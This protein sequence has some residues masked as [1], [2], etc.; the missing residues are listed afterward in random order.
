MVPV[1]TWVPVFPAP[2]VQM[3]AAMMSAVSPVGWVRLYFA[4]DA[5]LSVAVEMTAMLVPGLALANRP[6]GT[7]VTMSPSSTPASVPEIEAV[8]VPSK[9]LSEAA[10]LLIVRGLGATDWAGANGADV[11]A[12]WLMFP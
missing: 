2:P 7:S 1:A 11:L 4:A 12:R 3:L 6:E 8:V 10:A 5:P 9:Y